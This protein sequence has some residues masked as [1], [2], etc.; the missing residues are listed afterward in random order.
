MARI[1]SEV[2]IAADPKAI[3]AALDTAAGL[4]SW[5]TDDVEFPGGAGSTMV[6]GFDKAPLPFHLRVE[7]VGADTVRWA[8]VGDFPPH[9]V[10]TEVIWTL[11]PQDGGTLVHF[12]HDGW[13][14]DDGGFPMSAYT[15][16][17]LL[18]Y[19]KRHIED[20]ADTPLFRRG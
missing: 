9:W 6:L 17:E 8:N 3:V 20:G 5:W 7:Q 11:T 12:A 14:D 15:W 2:E 19:L 1:V 18:G 4:R 13:A 10:G 16:G